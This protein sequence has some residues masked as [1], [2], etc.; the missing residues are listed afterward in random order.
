MTETHVLV[1]PHSAQAHVMALLKLSYSLADQGL[2]VTLATADYVQAKLVSSLPDNR[3]DIHPNLRVVGITDGVPPEHQLNPMAQYM[4]SCENFPSELEKLIKEFGDSN[5]NRNFACVIA[6]ELLGPQVHEVAQKMG[7]PRLASYCIGTASIKALVR[8]IP[9]LIETGVID[10][11]GKP[12]KDGKIIW[13]SPRPG[14]EPAHLLWYCGGDG[15]DPNIAFQLVCRGDKVSESVHWVFCKTFNELEPAAIAMLPNIL[16]IGPLCPRDQ[17]ASLFL[18]DLSCLSWL[19]Q[20][21]AN[22]VIYLAFGS[23]TILDQSQ[24]DEL[25]L[26]LE[27]LGRP[28]LWV[29]RSDHAYTY[30]DGFQ[31]RLGHLGKVI[32]WAPQEKVL[33]HPSVACFVSHCGFNSFLDGLGVPFI[34]WPN[35]YDQF[36]NATS[37]TDDWKVGLSLN[38]D[39][40]GLISRK[41]IKSKVEQL[42]GDEEFKKNSVKLKEQA[43]KST[44]KDG[45]C[46]KNLQLFVE[47]LKS[48]K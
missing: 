3:K 42:L 6:D 19:D 18:E 12:K 5:E 33:S 43:I 23:H 32:S 46:T 20:H 8:S 38:P 29:V 13:S 47:A 1:V 48:L 16:P 35:C 4:G 45:S 36:F 17:L 30:P 24:F 14:I 21:A 28:F 2:K 39:E 10:E 26:G 44:S 15:M 22:S 41:E 7:I 31:N 40:D 11:C 9:K 37:M 34:C 27:L 25:A